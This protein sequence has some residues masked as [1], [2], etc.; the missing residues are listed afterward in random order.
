MPESTKVFNPSFLV[1][2]VLTASAGIRSLREGKPNLTNLA[3]SLFGFHFFSTILIKLS[4]FLE[5]PLEQACLSS[6]GLSCSLERTLQS[7]LFGTAIGLWILF[8]YSGCLLLW[9]LMTNKKQQGPYRKRGRIWQGIVVIY[10][11]VEMFMVLAK[12]VLS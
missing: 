1:C 9:R 2:M 4:D 11:L 8:L 5:E 6:G 12:I 10:F 7:L 3:S